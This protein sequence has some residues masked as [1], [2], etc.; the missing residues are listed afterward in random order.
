LW[1][2]WEHRADLHEAFLMLACCLI[3]WRR[4]RGSCCSGF[5]TRSGACR[6]VV[7]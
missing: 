4:L 3:C 5:P 6:A 2:R 1:A 7:P